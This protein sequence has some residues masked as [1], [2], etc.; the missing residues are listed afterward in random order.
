VPI[1]PE[2]FEGFGFA[3]ELLVGEGVTN[4][5]GEGTTEPA[6]LAVVHAVVP[7]VERGEEDNAVTVDF[8]LERAR[9]FVDF[10]N[11]FWTF[12]AQQNGCFFNR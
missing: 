4:C 3:D 2:V 5:R 8:A 12:R 1:P 7:H 9:R 10:L 6:V 11:Q